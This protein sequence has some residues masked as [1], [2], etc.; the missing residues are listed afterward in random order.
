[1]AGVP[2]GCK[3]CSGLSPAADLSRLSDWGFALWAYGRLSPGTMLMVNGDANDFEIGLH[4]RDTLFLALRFENCLQSAEGIHIG[5]DS[6]LT[7]GLQ[8]VEW[9]STR[10]GPR[11]SGVRFSL[12]YIRRKCPAALPGATDGTEPLHTFAAIFLGAATLRRRVL[13]LHAQYGR[14]RVQARSTAGA[15]GMAAWFVDDAEDTAAQRS[16]AG[17]ATQGTAGG[18]ARDQR[19][20]LGRRPA[21]RQRHVA[22]RRR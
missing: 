8:V 11:R 10:R 21:V 12:W 14:S 1:M 3:R 13:I 16:A 22:G 5:G 9:E 19:L 18:A 2:G 20:G 6:L 7:A 17:C 4:E 15:D